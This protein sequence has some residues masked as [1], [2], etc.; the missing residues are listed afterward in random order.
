MLRKTR[1][2]ARCSVS[3][4]H[5]LL[6]ATRGLFCVPHTAGSGVCC[7]ADRRQELLLPCREL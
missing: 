4:M 7:A 5:T 3:L 6:C 1:E 2:R